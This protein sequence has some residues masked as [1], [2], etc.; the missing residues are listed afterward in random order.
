MG[1]RHALTIAGRHDGIGGADLETVQSLVGKIY[2]R[3][4][5]PF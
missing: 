2:I 1:F 5:A 3:W 4:P